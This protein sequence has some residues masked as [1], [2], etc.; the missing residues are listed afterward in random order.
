VPM[1]QVE[2]SRALSRRPDAQHVDTG[3]QLVHPGVAPRHA[4]D[5]REERH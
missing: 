4:D 3:Q 1:D 2:R 5:P